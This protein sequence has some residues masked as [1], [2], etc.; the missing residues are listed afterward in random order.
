MRDILLQDTEM[1]HALPRLVDPGRLSN[2]A[3][4]FRYVY[5]KGNIHKAPRP[6]VWLLLLAA[7]GGGGGGGGGGPTTSGSGSSGAPKMVELSGFAYNRP[8][9]GGVVWLDVNRNQ[10]IDADDYRVPGTVN[11]KGEYRGQVPE[12]IAKS[13]VM[14]DTTTITNVN[15]RG[16]LPDTLLAPEGSKVV[17]PVTHALATGDI[18][19][20]QLKKDFD[21]LSQNPYEQTTDSVQEAI[22]K[23]VRDALPKITDI[24]KRTSDNTRRIE[25]LEA[26]FDTLQK[27]FDTLNRLQQSEEVSSEPVVV[28]AEP[29]IPAP[30]PVAPVD[31][32]PTDLRIET[33]LDTLQQDHSGAV[34]LAIIRITDDD[35]GENRLAGLPSGAPVEYRNITRTG[36]ELWLK[37][38]AVLHNIAPGAHPYQ[39]ALANSLA[40]GLAKTFT[41]TITDV[42]FAPQATQG[43]YSALLP[44]RPAGAEQPAVDTQVRV[45]ITNRDSDNLIYSVDN[46]AFEMRGNA[47]WLKAGKGLDF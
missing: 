1:H 18:K 15:Y 29:E 45:G 39:I 6:L 21:Y 26:Q 37:D 46:Q 38:D 31:S 36:A 20:E 42:D 7:C 4:E 3:D 41:L 43:T 35:L 28:P 44:E 14:V 8:L 40:P 30:P 17:S 19:R 12:N 10:R 23:A 16:I 34:R 33:H 25:L 27:R 11:N 13:P 32:A 5:R 22:N 2:F 9:E 24:I 47:L